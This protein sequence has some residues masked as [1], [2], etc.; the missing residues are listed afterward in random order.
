MGIQDRVRS[1]A[2]AVL[3]KQEMNHEV[4]KADALLA[5]IHHGGTAP[6]RW[7]ASSRRGADNA[8]G[9]KFVKRIVFGNL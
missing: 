6:H 9:S 4:D 5:D 3:G 8:A 2:K 1:P 7:N